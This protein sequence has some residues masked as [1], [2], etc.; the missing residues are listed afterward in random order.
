MQNARK[1][2]DIRAAFTRGNHRGRIYLETTMSH[3]TMELLRLTPGILQQNHRIYTNAIP[4][5]D[6]AA[7]LTL[8]QRGNEKLQQGQWI[9][10]FRGT[11]RNDVGL[12]WRK[13]HD[14]KFIIL[15]VPR[16]GLSDDYIIN[17]QKRQ[18]TDRWCSRPP[19]A[20]FN[21]RAALQLANVE[22]ADGLS[23][24][25]SGLYTF[26]NHCYDHGLLRKTVKPTSISSTRV[27]MPTELYCLFKESEHP[28]IS[29]FPS[30][31]EWEFVEG[32]KVHLVAGPG[33]YEGQKGTISTVQD[34]HIIVALAESDGGG[35]VKVQSDQLLKAFVIGDFVKIL[36]G[37]S[38]DRMGWIAKVD[39]HDME[40]VERFQNDPLDKVSG[41]T[42]PANISC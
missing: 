32:D 23:L 3:K 13:R 18:R 4:V 16:L 14:G 21:V 1:E 41:I 37:V 17:R 35:I 31:F 27:Y 15:L 38:K 25:Q 22:A 36:R 10:V 8:P 28:D 42:S 9:R 11:Y 12:I 34:T 6:R 39:D 30:A 2:H 7:T 29:S 5:E 33:T 19:P 26:D 24:L 40:I 20:L